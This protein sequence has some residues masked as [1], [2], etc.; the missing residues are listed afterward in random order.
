MADDKVKAND[1]VNDNV[2]N[3]FKGFALP[4]SNFLIDVSG[5]LQSRLADRNITV[6]APFPVNLRCIISGSS[7]C[8]KTVFLKNLYTQHTI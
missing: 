7:E 6:Y 2:N 5:S 1:N 8:G 4:S 3:N